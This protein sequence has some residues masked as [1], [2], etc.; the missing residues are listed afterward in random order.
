VEELVMLVSRALALYLMDWAFSEVTH[1]PS[2]LCS[3]SHRMSQRSVLATGDYFS[4]LDVLSVALRVFR[5][6]S[7][8]CIAARLYKC[9]VSAQ[10]YFWPGSKE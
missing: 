4:D 5:I 8:L 3:L 7:L 1:I 6:V 9:G 2:S 10:A